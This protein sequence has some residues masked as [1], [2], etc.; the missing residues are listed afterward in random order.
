MSGKRT[1]DLSVFVNCPFDEPFR[2]LMRAMVF[3]IHDCGFIAR[4]ALEVDDSSQVRIHKIIR[5][6][7][8]CRLGLHD[9]SRT[10]LDPHSDLP[11]FNMPLELGIFLGAKELGSPKQK[12][13]SALVLD[14]ERYRYQKYCSDIA[15]QDIAAH[16]D[17]PK[18][19][20]RVVRNWLSSSQPDVA[21]PGGAKIFERYSHFLEDL[22]PYCE[23]LLLDPAEL[24]FGDHTNLVV[25]WQN[26]NQW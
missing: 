24:T 23:S 14:R 4:S 10:E 17:N 20:I 13:K 12:R 1:Y 2:D 9:I 19:A 21:V 15:G 18:D 16:G 25:A 7:S 11:R 3:T 8:E 22:P 6:V 5:I 26:A